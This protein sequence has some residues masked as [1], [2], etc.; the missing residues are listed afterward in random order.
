MK[1]KKFEISIPQIVIVRDYHEFSE[2]QDFLN[3]IGLSDIRVTDISFTVE[4]KLLGVVHNA[5]DANQKSFRD[6]KKK[7]RELYEDEEPF[8]ADEILNRYYEN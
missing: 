5:E 1:F 3:K 7:F 4:G 6:M 2:Y 8:D